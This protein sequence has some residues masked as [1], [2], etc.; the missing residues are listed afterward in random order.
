MA[1]P[2]DFSKDDWLMDCGASTHVCT[3]REMFVDYTPE[4]S[5]IKGLGALRIAGQ[6]TVTL[7]FT[8]KGKHI[9]HHLQ[10]VAHVPDAPNCL[11]LQ[12]RFTDAGGCIESQDDYI[13]LKKDSAL[14]GIGHK[15]QKLYLLHAKADLCARDK[16]F[17]A[18]VPEYSWDKWHKRY[19]HLCISAINRARWG[20]MVT[21]LNINETTTA[22]RSCETCLKGKMARKKYPQEAKHCSKTAGERTMTDV[23]GPAPLQSIHRYNYFINFTD[24]ARRLCHLQFLKTKD[25]AFDRITSYFRMI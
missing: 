9:T 20:N 1:A 10:N 16:A 2:A 14:V 11:L 21:G 6:G 12:G 4:N 8:V 18:T 17:V 5:T 3:T 19:G 13:Y 23:W 24:D 22:S 15:V 7:Q 25:E